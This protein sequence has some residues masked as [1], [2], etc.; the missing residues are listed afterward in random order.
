MVCFKSG[1]LLETYLHPMYMLGADE[2]SGG[3]SLSLLVMM[4]EMV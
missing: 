3:S 2:V 1:R 4:K